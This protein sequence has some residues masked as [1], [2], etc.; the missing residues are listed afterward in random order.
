MKK[1]VILFILFALSLVFAV[2]LVVNENQKRSS[3]TLLYNGNTEKENKINT[4][5][6]EGKMPSATPL[7][8]GKSE[9]TLKPTEVPAKIS[10]QVPLF[11][12]ISSPSNSQTV[13]NTSI[14]VKGMTTPQTSVMVNEFEL[15]ADAQGAFSKSLSLDEGENYI[16]IV[17][18][19][20][21]GEVVEKELIITREVQE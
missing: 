20:S 21:E 11:L 4:E 13:S 14:L 15:T 9:P 19:N 1:I 16:N 18:Y 7:P 12:T 5:F 2:F 10:M 8:T 6:F 17:A 3:A